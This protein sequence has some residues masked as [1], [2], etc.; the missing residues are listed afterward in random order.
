MFKK[1]Y[2]RANYYHFT[3]LETLP[4]ILK[5]DTL[6]GSKIE[7]DIDMGVSLTR[8]PSLNFNLCRITLDGNKLKKHGYVLKYF[9]FFKDDVEELEQA[10]KRH[11]KRHPE[12]DKNKELLYF[13]SI[14]DKRRVESEEVLIGDLTDLH[15]YV[16]AIDIAKNKADLSANM[17]IF[18]D[19]EDYKNEYGLDFDV[20]VSSK[21]IKLPRKEISGKLPS[22]FKKYEDKPIDI[23]N[24][25]KGDT[26]E[27][28]MQLEKAIVKKVDKVANQLDQI[29]PTKLDMTKTK[30]Y[31]DTIDIYSFNIDTVLRIFKL[32]S[33]FENSPEANELVSHVML[34]EH[35]LKI[36]PEE[37]EAFYRSFKSK[38][39]KIYRDILARVQAYTF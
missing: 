13:E 31:I 1:S 32:M 19:I 36:D 23:F 28:Q 15:E 3:K 22:R 20:T 26:H 8:N 24:I 25:N 6:K 39:I 12:F 9:D 37:K 34:Y 10:H 11:K 27:K 4:L 29:K 17:S 18:E 2:D 7:G 14:H 5:S 35:I 16:L 21:A 38:L 30:K 33:I